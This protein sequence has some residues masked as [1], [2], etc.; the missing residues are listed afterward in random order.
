M[1]DRQSSALDTVATVLFIIRTE[2]TQF[3]SE[4]RSGH[5]GEFFFQEC[6]RSRGIQLH[7]AFLIHL[8]SIFA[9]QKG[10]FILTIYRRWFLR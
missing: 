3:S 9:K 8:V 10:S 5:Y 2:T 1:S 7:T 4:P 6:Q